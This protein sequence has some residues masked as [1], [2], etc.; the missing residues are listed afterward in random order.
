LKFDF[1]ASGT[2]E[3]QPLKLDFD[4]DGTFEKTL[5]PV[6]SFESGSPK[7]SMPMPVPFS[8]HITAFKT[9]NQNQI[10]KITFPDVSG[11]SWNWQIKKAGTLLTPSSNS[12][13]TPKILDVT[14]NSKGLAVGKYYDTMTVALSYGKYKIDCPILF[15][16]NVYSKS[17]ISDIQLTPE[18]V[19]VKPKTQVQFAA[20]AYDQ[21]G[22]SIT[23]NLNWVASGGTIDQNGLFTS[24]DADGEYIVTVQS[25]DLSVK[26]TAV[27]IVDKTVDV[28]ESPKESLSS[29]PEITIYPNPCSDKC[30]IL[31][32]FPSFSNIRIKL[33]NTL[34]VEVLPKF[35][36][37]YSKGS[38]EF[39]VNCPDLSS[40]I[41]FFTFEFEDS[42][43]LRFISS[44]GVI[45]QN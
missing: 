34:G 24:A 23:S 2:T 19:T 29:E 1:N 26:D 16:I 7:P 22:K 35:E 44:K 28:A 27:V 10:A 30:N 18:F 45:I 15:V 5:L 43:G 4:G 41:Y 12:G 6:E 42:S 37:F 9:D 32:H 33:T 11:P 3:N 39:T 21:S 13:N 40:G 8:V 36:G 20:K 31:V 38:H 17:D 14:V 25:N